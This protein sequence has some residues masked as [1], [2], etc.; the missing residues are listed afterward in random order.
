MIRTTRPLAWIA[1]GLLGV[2]VVLGAI[3]AVDDAPPH[4]PL[5]GALDPGAESASDPPAF[6]AVRRTLYVPGVV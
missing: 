1:G 4:P 6:V 2:G 3:T 5:A